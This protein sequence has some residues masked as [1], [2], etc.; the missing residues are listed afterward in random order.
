[1]DANIAQERESYHQ[2]GHVQDLHGYSSNTSSRCSL[3]EAG[4]TFID[5]WQD[6][7]QRG[8]GGDA[9]ISYNEHTRRSSSK[10]AH[11][12]SMPGT[13]TARTSSSSHRRIPIRSFS[14]RFVE[15]LPEF[16]PYSSLL[17]TNPTS[18]HRGRFRSSPA[19]SFVLRRR[20]NATNT[21]PLRTPSRSIN[22]DS[23]HQV[24]AQ[25]GGYTHVNEKLEKNKKEPQRWKPLLIA[26]ACVSIAAV[27][28]KSKAGSSNKQH[29]PEMGRAHS[30]HYASASHTGSTPI[31][32]SLLSRKPSKL[33]KRPP[34]TVRHEVLQSQ[35]GSTYT[36]WRRSMVVEVSVDV[37][38][39]SSQRS[40]KS[41]ASRAPSSSA[42]TAATSSTIRR[43]LLGKR[44]RRNALT[45]ICRSFLD[46]CRC[47]GGHS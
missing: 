46:T 3:Q 44:P 34:G 19:V 27:A 1:M 32:A 14:S 5:P 13:P 20:S 23:L 7:Q 35:R 4:P 21:S 30:T 33:K 26:S 45:R 12:T 11:S 15:D 28:T 6:G 47:R 40:K 22:G 16:Q 43:R 39:R 38:R 10:T 17:G 42:R 37:S 36:E 8:V 31:Q 9:T 2:E 41:T 18:P 29:P 25:Q 24:P